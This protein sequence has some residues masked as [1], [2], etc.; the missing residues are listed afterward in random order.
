MPRHQEHIEMST[1]KLEEILEERY[2]ESI[3]HFDRIQVGQPFE[4]PATTHVLE[5]ARRLRAKC[6]VVW[7]LQNRLQGASNALQFLT[8]I[9]DAQL[10]IFKDAGLWVPFEVQPQFDSLVLNFPAQ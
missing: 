8:A 4:K 3:R 9:P 10:H 2:S 6:L 1:A 7:G 5:Q